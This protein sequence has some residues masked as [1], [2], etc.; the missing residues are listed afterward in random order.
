MGIRRVTL[1]VT[2]VPAPLFHSEGYL[3]SYQCGS[4]GMSK[5]APRSAG[6]LAICLDSN[7][8]GYSSW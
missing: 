6:L 4:V 7:L 5:N 3:V 2:N 8:C 1:F